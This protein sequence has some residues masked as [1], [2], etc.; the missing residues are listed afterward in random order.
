M[1]RQ[2]SKAPSS[3]IDG[4]RLQPLSAA[5]G[6]CP[7][8]LTD[9]GESAAQ[10]SAE[11]ALPLSTVLSWR[12]PAPATIVTQH[13]SGLEATTLKVTGAAEEGVRV[14]TLCRA[15]RLLGQADEVVALARF[16]GPYCV[17]C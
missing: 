2:R 9:I 10:Q 7:L 15:T 17:S 4:R 6:A 14:A 3:I 1:N 8:D 11:M 13:R 16:D 5:W 12:V